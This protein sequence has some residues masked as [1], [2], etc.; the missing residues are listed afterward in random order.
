MKI[1]ILGGSFDPVHNGH[2]ELAEK[3]LKQLKL[4]F[5]FFVPAF[6]VP[7]KSRR[8]SAAFHRKKMLQLAVKNNPKFLISDFE[9][10]LKK[11]TYTYQTLRYFR[12]TYPA[13]QLYL[14][15]GSDSVLDL[16]KW[17]NYKELLKKSKIVFA[18]R[19]NYRALNKKNNIMLDGKIADI[20]SSVI[21]RRIKK[22]LPLKGLTP[23]P[24]ENY[25][26][27]NGLYK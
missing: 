5:L 27:K 14:V 23:R 20:S 13:S 17:E 2:I 19:K 22:G 26:K 18:E 10:K 21:R 1:G 4:D 9:L 12:K 15:L 11:R 25:I 8:L 3:S 6:S 24:V 7:H 16:K